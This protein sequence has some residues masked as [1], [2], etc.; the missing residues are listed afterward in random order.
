MEEKLP[1]IW[2]TL[3]THTV[4]LEN[5]KSNYEFFGNSDANESSVT[6]LEEKEIVSWLMNN[7]RS[8]EFILS[9]IIEKTKVG[10]FFDTEVKEP[11]LSK[12]NQRV[13]G[14]IDFLIC[15]VDRPDLVTVI[16]FKRI[17]IITKEN[18][19]VKINRFEYN[20][21]KGIKQIKELR[22][23]DFHKTYLGIIIEDDG[24]HTDIKGTIFKSSKG[25]NVDD[26]YRI[27]FDSKLDRHAG[28][29]FI[30]VNQP[31]G[32]DYNLRNNLMIN[33]L[34]YAT[35][36]TQSVEK[37]NRMRVLLKEN[38]TARNS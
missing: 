28:V 4:P 12:D 30:M 16:E 37:T 31:T 18:G 9:E 38:N 26:I 11:I 22:K 13:I 3:V 25:N 27:A 6:E 33:I 23:F 20:R 35:P 15:P 21:D 36:V 10:Y 34:K 1:K 8:R 7:Q 32:E 5:G 14:D 29:L 19:E 2:K 17:K 24:R